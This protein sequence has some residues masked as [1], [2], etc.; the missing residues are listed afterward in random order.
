MPSAFR[1]VI[2]RPKIEMTKSIVFYILLTYIQCIYIRYS[3]EIS[4]MS[5]KCSTYILLVTNNANDLCIL[6]INAV[7]TQILTYDTHLCKQLLQLLT[8]AS[9]SAQ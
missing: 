5:Y 9:H 2:Y 4:C 8:Q 6:A 1:R 3:Y 7:K